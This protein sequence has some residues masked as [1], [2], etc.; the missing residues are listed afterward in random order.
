MHIRNL[1]LPGRAE[2]VEFNDMLLAATLAP[3][4]GGQPTTILE[5]E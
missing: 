5:L 3:F 4:W 1:N 2:D